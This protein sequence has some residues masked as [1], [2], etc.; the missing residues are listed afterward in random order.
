MI[1]I[2]S[3]TG[4]N[5][6]KKPNTKRHQRTAYISAYLQAKINSQGLTIA[7][8][9][10]GKK[11]S[12]STFENWLKDHK[13]IN[14]DEEAKGLKRKKLN[15]DDTQDTSS[16]T[17]VNQ[18]TIIQLFKRHSMK[19]RNE[20]TNPFI[21]G[22]IKSQ[23]LDQSPEN[24]LGQLVHNLQDYSINFDEPQYEGIRERL[25]SFRM[26]ILDWLR[27]DSTGNIPIVLEPILLL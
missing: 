27:N 2:S 22:Y 3:D 1:T 25:L 9:C 23:I 19:K 26:D 18:T 8:F 14:E 13:R 10:K 21:I 11:F 15:E 12:K 16:Q 20:P 17:T 5:P 7:A 6:T 24:F 4:T